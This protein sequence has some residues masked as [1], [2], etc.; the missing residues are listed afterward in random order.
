MAELSYD[1][2]LIL[3]PEVPKGAVSG[4]LLLLQAL[5]LQGHLTVQQEE[6]L[7]HLACQND[8]RLLRAYDTVGI[9]G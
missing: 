6:L 8:T 9:Q 4:L 1:E 2:G 5:K 3:P 7:R